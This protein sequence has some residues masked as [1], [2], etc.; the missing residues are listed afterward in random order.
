MR[1]ELVHPGGQVEG[2]THF[3]GGLRE[4]YRPRQG[5]PARQERAVVAQKK[6]AEQQRA[7]EEERGRWRQWQ[8]PLQWHR[9]W[10]WGAH[11]AVQTDGAEA[12]GAAACLT[13]FLFVLLAVFKQFCLCCLGNKRFPSLPLCLHQGRCTDPRPTMTKA[14]HGN[15]GGQR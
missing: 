7:K 11:Q 6:R 12:W 5:C 14:T 13:D 8:P 2:H 15:P 10:S 4:L 1:R 3:P 9:S